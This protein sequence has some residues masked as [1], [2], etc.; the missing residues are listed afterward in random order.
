M[1]ILIAL[2]MAGF[3]YG[4]ILVDNFPYNVP[5]FIVNLVCALGLGSL[6]SLLA[7]VGLGLVYRWKLDQRREECRQ[8]IARL[9]ESRL[10]KSLTT[11]W[12][13]NRDGEEDDRAGRV[14]GKVND[15]PVKIES[16]A[17]G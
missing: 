1:A 9:L 3:V 2:V 5:Q 10:G 13:D 7:F 12:R 6:I 15:S 11:P 8:R 17:R 14:A 16:A 4:T